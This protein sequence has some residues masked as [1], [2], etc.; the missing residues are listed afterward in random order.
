MSLLISIVT[1]SQT[2]VLKYSFAYIYEY[3]IPSHKNAVSGHPGIVPNTMTQIIWDLRDKWSNL[4]SSIIQGDMVIG[5]LSKIWSS[6]L[7]R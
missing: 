3:S 1:Q 6:F 4:H 2:W 5:S 7:V